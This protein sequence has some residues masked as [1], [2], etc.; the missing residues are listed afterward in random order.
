MTTRAA[1]ELGLQEGSTLDLLFND[2]G[3]QREGSITSAHINIGKDGALET[4]FERKAGPSLWEK[5]K[6]DVPAYLEMVYYKHFA[7]PTPIDDDEEEEDKLEYEAENRHRKRNRMGVVLF[8]LL[9]VLLVLSRLPRPDLPT[10]VP[11]LLHGAGRAFRLTLSKLWKNVFL[12]WNQVWTVLA[13][14]RWPS[15]PPPP[16]PAAIR[17]Q[18]GNG[19]LAILL[20]LVLGT[21][22]ARCFFGILP[23]REEEQDEKETNRGGRRAPSRPPTPPPARTPPTSPP[24]SRGPSPAPRRRGDDGWYMN[25]RD[26]KTFHA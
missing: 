20:A 15:P 10:S 21:L 5:L 14:P 2:D 8:L 3:D 12:M 9:M 22:G 19:V 11:A 25:L 16:P 1:K 18:F 24:R 4:V 7:P 23:A 17:S 26:G 6:E 13:L